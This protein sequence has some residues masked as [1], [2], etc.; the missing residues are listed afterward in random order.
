MTPVRRIHVES[1]VNLAGSGGAAVWSF[2]LDRWGVC[3]QA[4]STW[5]AVAVWRQRHGPAQVVEYLPGDERAFRRN[6]APA[7]D[8]ELDRTLA[9]L[10]E[11]RERSIAILDALP[12]E[13][14]DFDDPDREL[15]VWARWRTIRQTLWHICDTESRYY[16]PQT[17]LPAKERRDPLRDELLDSHDHV[18]SVLRSMARDAVHRPDGEIWTATKL[19]RRLAWHE[20]GELAAVNTLLAGW[21]ADGRG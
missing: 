6:S 12:D 1:Q 17:G 5:E 2:D 16:L 7:S 14:L 21:Q 4:G 10:A 19:L 18:M 13:T 3:E 8:A 15:P 11:A 20:R 9:I